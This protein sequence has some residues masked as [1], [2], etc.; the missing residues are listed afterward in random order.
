MTKIFKTAFLWLSLAIINYRYQLIFLKLFI[1]IIVLIICIF[2]YIFL[3]QVILQ[4]WPLN[5]FIRI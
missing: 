2:W 4:I 3:L 5:F 1:I